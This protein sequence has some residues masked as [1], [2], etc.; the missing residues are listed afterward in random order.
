MTLVMAAAALA[1]TA[2]VVALWW[3]LRR[4]ALAV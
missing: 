4:P 3:Q 1:A 2:S